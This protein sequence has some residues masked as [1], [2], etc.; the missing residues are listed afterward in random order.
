LLDLLALMAST[1]PGLLNEPTA[2]LTPQE[3]DEFSVTFRQI[4]QDG[5]SVI[6][7]SHQLYDG[8]AISVFAE[9]TTQERLGPLRAG[10][11]TE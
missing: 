1:D 8:I 7:F 11:K 6:V 5:H 9:N 4:R 3:E 2:V 10:A